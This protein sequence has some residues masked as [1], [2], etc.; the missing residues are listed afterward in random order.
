MIKTEK[1]GKESYFSFPGFLFAEY[2]GTIAI[3][4]KNSTIPV[5]RMG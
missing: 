2:A 3:P 4:V 5:Q 1:P